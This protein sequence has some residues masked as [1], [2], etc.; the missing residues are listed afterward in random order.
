[1]G[2]P[3]KDTLSPQTTYEDTRG[4][5]PKMGGKGNKQTV[6]QGLSQLMQETGGGK[7]H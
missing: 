4:K 1:M 3:K 7:Y 5:A 6:L 2:E